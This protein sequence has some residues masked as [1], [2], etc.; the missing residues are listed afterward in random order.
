MISLHE[1]GEWA[2]V[3]DRQ[4]LENYLK[5]IWFEYK[6]LNIYENGNSIENK[7]QSQ[8]FLRFD[9]NFLKANNFVG[10]I[11]NDKDLIEIFP[12]V[13]NNH[14]NLSNMYDMILMLKLIFY[15]FSYC[16][17]WRLQFSKVS[18]DSFDIDSFPELI[19]NLIGNQFLET[20]TRQPL[21]MYQSLEETLDTPKGRINFK[22]YIN[23]NI[24][25]GNY[26]HIDCNYEPFLIDN[27]VN[28][29]IKY[30]TRLLMNQT[31]LS[32]NLRVLQEIIFILDDVDDLP[33]SILDIDKIHLNS[34]YEEYIVVKHCCEIILKQHLYSSN[35]Y[36]LT[37]WCL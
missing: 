30:C 21:S 19:I 1:Y 16:R 10:F 15:C 13:F 23:D 33:C 22:R 12:K 26:H 32:E 7:N 36:E 6:D 20:I 31:K 24:S 35:S 14:L 37:Q 4:L 27:N 2:E 17:K 28:R 8:P 9:G 5:S 25:H 3:K 11:Q 29:V 18:L 34:F